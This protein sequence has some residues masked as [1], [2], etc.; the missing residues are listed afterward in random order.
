MTNLRDLVLEVE[1]AEVTEAIARL[2]NR[3]E[4]EW[5][6][7][8]IANVLAQLRKLVPDPAGAEWQLRIELTPAIDPDEQ[9][10]WDVS[11]TKEGDPER[12]GFDLSPWAEWLAGCVPQ[13]L[14]EKMTRQR[15]RRALRVGNDLLLGSHR[16]KS[17]RRA[18]SWSAALK[19]SNGSKAELIPWEQA[20]ERLQAG[21]RQRC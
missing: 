15:D 16:R 11:C 7:E 14:L 2:Y 20:K 9:P 10:C 18:P 4:T 5:L 8:A 3:S 19:R 17:L 13:S 21:R 1:E 12:Y 6:P